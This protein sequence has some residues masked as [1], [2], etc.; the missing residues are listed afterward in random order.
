MIIEKVQM[1]RNFYDSI[2]ESDRLNRQHMENGSKMLLDA[3]LWARQGRNPGT[4]E[5][6]IRLPPDFTNKAA[7]DYASMR[8]NRPEKRPS[9]ERIRE[10]IE[11]GLEAH[12]I[13]TELKCSR[14]KV[15]A[16]M[17]AIKLQRRPDR[18]DE[19]IRTGLWG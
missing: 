5:E 7:P 9:N 4:R 2:S 8:G 1:K 11:R 14:Q 18:R 6:P 10:M 12:Q 13:A 16:I 3:I 17:K 19:M 15:V